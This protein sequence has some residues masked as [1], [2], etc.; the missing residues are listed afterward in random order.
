MR[1]RGPESASR[2]LARSGSTAG[3]LPRSARTI[4]VIP[5]ICPA[6][7]AQPRPYR[8]GLRDGEQR[9][10]TGEVG[11]QVGQDE[12]GLLAVVAVPVALGCG[13]QVGES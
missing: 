9:A 3:R 7:T 4:A 6:G 13:L 11:D 2:S 8:R 12:G 1:R 10:Q 5:A